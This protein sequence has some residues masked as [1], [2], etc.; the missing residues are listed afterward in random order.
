MRL[1]IMKEKMKKKID[2]QQGHAIIWHDLFL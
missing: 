2:K 1:K